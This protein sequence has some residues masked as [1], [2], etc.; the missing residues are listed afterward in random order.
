MAAQQKKQ[1]LLDKEAYQKQLKQKQRQQQQNK[2]GN[3]QQAIQKQL[4]ALQAKEA[5]EAAAKNPKKKSLVWVYLLGILLVAFLV[6]PKPSIVVYRNLHLIAESIYIPSYFGTQAKLLDSAGDIQIDD[7][8]LWLYICN[9]YAKEKQC[10]RFDII[11]QKGWIDVIK[12]L[13]E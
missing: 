3:Q 9:T 8:N 4:A 10:Q 2:I 12:K 7:D 5:A 11:E 6:T 13:S 1:K